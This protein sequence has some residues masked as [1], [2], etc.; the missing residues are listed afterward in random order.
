MSNK[1]LWRGQLSDDGHIGYDEDEKRK[2]KVQHNF[3][4][5]N[6]ESIVSLRQEK[7]STPKDC[8][9]KLHLNCVDDVE[10]LDEHNHEN[11]PTN[12]SECPVLKEARKVWGLPGE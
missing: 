2:K 5:N 7:V 3:G 10:G 4:P 8:T 1:P 6:V 12:H 9:Q 11:N